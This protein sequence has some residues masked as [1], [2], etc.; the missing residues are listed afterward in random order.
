MRGYLRAGTGHHDDARLAC[1]AFVRRWPDLGSDIPGEAAV[2]HAVSAAQVAGLAVCL[3][4][5]RQAA[6][7]VAVT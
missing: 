7:V 1:E 3:E 5:L 4:E 6:V 2:N